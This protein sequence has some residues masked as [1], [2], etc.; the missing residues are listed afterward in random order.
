MLT[1]STIP[2]YVCAMKI[3]HL[4]IVMCCCCLSARNIEAAANLISDNFN[5]M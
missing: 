4:D 2:A 1:F 3:I 5:Q